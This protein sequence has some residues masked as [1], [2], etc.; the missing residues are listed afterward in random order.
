MYV[1]FD[2]LYQNAPMLALFSP[3]P[4]PFF[5]PPPFFIR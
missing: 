5:S 3:S 1:I 4:F 2:N